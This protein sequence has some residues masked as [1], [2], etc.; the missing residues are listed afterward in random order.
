M[1]IGTPYTVVAA[2]PNVANSNT[3]T[4][5]TTA[6]VPQG[7]T[8]FLMVAS[9]GTNPA[10]ISGITGVSGSWEIE[11]QKHST[12]TLGASIARIVAGTGGIPSGTSL[13]VTLDAVTIR[14]TYAAIGVSGLVDVAADVVI[15]AS[16]NSGTPDSGSSAATTQAAEL[17][18]ACFSKVDPTGGETGTPDTSH[19]TYTEFMDVVAGASLWGHGYAEYQILSATGFQE[20]IFTPTSTA[21]NWVAILCCFKSVSGTPPVN[22]VLPTVTGGNTIGSV[23]S[24]STGT[25]TGSATIVFSYQWQRSPNGTS[26][27]ANIA[28]A[29]TSAYTISPVDAGQHLRCQV[30]GTNGAGTATANTAAT[31]QVTIPTAGNYPTVVVEWSPTTNPGA[32]PAWVDISSLTRAVSTQT[33]RQDETGSVQGGTM[34]LT[35]DNRTGAFDP[36]YSSGINFGNVKPIRQVRV[37]A[38]YSGVT[39]PIWQGYMQAINPSW[40]DFTNDD[41]VVADCVDA[42]E[43]LNNAAIDGLN[44]VL[45]DSGARV[46]DVLAFIGYTGATN[47]ETGN[48][49]IVGDFMSGSAL[50]HLQDVE[51]TENGMLFTARDGTLTFQNRHHRILL[52][53]TSHGIIGDGGSSEIG[54]SSTD[55]AYDTT[56]IY[57]DVTATN[58][59]GAPANSTDATSQAQ[60][61]KRSLQRSL[62]IS[63]MNETQSCADFLRNRYAQPSLRFPTITINPASNPSLAWPVILGLELSNRVTVTRRPPHGGLIAFDCYVEGVAHTITPQGWQVVLNLSPVSNQ[64]YWILGDAVN[65]VLGSTTVPAY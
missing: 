35:L 62:L 61:W 9:R 10:V 31:V 46:A 43:I 45:E 24:C 41:Q 3:L 37:R 51:L 36:L 63:D 4:A 49:E 34:T 40:P 64:S 23:P 56:Y 8:L 21:D 11:T 65:G 25:W 47:L 33:G 22:T 1:A 58:V 15:G 28:G 44:T 50:S 26:G 16:G 38:V 53:T 12:S 17:A 7:D 13:N 30:T 5:V 57:N 14:K 18:V 60:Y 42:F 55:P 52:E 59:D 32:V 19:G 29:T 20:A 27:W 54:Y 48:S 2:A 6:N 39:Y